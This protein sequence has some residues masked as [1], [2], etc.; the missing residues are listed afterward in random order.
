MPADVLV[1][2]LWTTPPASALNT[3]QV[4]VSRLRRALGADVVATDGRGYELTLNTDWQDAL[5]SLADA[6]NQIRAGD[7]KAALQQLETAEALWRGR[8]LRDAPGAGGAEV[9]GGLGHRL[10]VARRD[11]ITTLGDCALQIG[12]PA[13]A[14]APVTA[15]L[16][17]DPVDEQL[18]AL[19][20]R[21][22]AGCGRQAEALALF[23]R[24][25]RRLVQELG[26]EPG[27]LLAAAQRDVLLGEPGRAMADHPTSDRASIL[28]AD[29]VPRPATPL[30]GRS[31]E[32]AE[33]RRW[34]TGDGGRLWTVVGL[35][36][37]GKTHLVLEALSSVSTEADPPR[38]LW[39]DLSAATTLASV[40]DQVLRAAQVTAVR[41]APDTSAETVSSALSLWLGGSAGLIVLDNAEESQPALAA[42]VSAWLTATSGL[43]ILVT[44]R[45][46][47]HLRGERVQRL[48][49]LPAAGSA[50]ELFVARAIAAGAA[51][52]SQ[53]DTQ[54][55]SELCLHL[56]GLP[57][58]IEIVAARCGTVS[59]H[60]LL[61]QLDA[62]Q[63][64]GGADLVAVVAMEH[65]HLDVALR[66]RSL[67]AAL[68]GSVDR[69]TPGARAVLETASAFTGAFTE[70]TLEKLVEPG[71]DV[72]AGLDELHAA[73]LLATADSGWTLLRIVRCF[74]RGRLRSSGR[75]AS[76]ML[77][78]CS[79]GCRRDRRRVRLGATHAGERGVRRPAAPVVA[80]GPRVHR[81]G[82]GG[83]RR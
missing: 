27:A 52:F 64:T 49:P 4:H 9:A 25:R 17:R 48:A 53:A 62:N 16:D 40:F 44:S 32:L 80:T 14:L 13:R 57:L 47:L 67:E 58:A 83:W 38:T 74:A 19:A 41:G 30:I 34:L 26:I 76:V 35:G 68:R 72:A 59:P 5:A 70:A 21:L 71:T 12:A 31:H 24:T 63:S 81:L 8:P 28:G 22:L 2:Q 20:I 73:A 51:P 23:S 79:P 65:P 37:V 82:T 18:S 77:R 43:R 61:A 66:H 75:E 56:D 55:A 46:A 45:V 7:L 6:R 50:V 29:G 3:L 69:L 54:A 15:A 36:G 42:E 39:I 60:R 11:I 78:L 33:L 10:E 1:D